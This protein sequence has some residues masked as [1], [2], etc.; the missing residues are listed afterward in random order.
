MTSGK[1][2]SMITAATFLVISAS[3]VFLLSYL[4]YHYNAGHTVFARGG[5]VKVFYLSVLASHIVLAAVVPVLAILLVWWGLSGRRERHRAL[6]RWAWPG[7]VYVSLTG[8][9][10]YF[11]LYHWFPAP[12]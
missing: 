11:M 10:V 12:A 5:A 9:L 6:A 7:W 4:Y 1:K 2:K 8:L 3:L